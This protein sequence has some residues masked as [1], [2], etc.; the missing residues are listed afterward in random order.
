MIKKI[1]ILSGIMIL[2][3]SSIVYAGVLV[4]KVYFSGYPIIINGDEY[5]SEMPILSYQDR[6]Y[7]A[8]REFSNMVGVDVEF[9]DSI[10]Y[11]EYGRTKKDSAIETEIVSEHVSSE[12]G[13]E[14]SENDNEGNIVY[15]SKSGKKYH[16]LKD[17]NTKICY[18]ISLNEAINKGYEACLKCIEN[19]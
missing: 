19:K 12:N 9:K 17:C 14:F 16:L 18:S 10:I 5:S 7:V 2:L 8:L 11:I 6:T 4:K 13:I 3:I 15:I 1:L